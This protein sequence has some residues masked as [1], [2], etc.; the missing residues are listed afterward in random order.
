MR[1]IGLIVSSSPYLRSAL[2]GWP[3]QNL[4]NSIFPSDFRFTRFW[5][6]YGFFAFSV[7]KEFFLLLCH[8][9]DYAGWRLLSNNDDDDN[10]NNEDNHGKETTAKTTT[11]KITTAKTITMTMTMVLLSKPFER[12]SGLLYAWFYTKKI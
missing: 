10:D 3:L 4:D 6:Y 12:L 9:L 5:F 8:P 7:F 11:A 1:V 2:G